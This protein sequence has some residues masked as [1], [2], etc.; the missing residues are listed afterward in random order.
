MTLAEL[1]GHTAKQ[2]QDGKLV[3]DK[4][5]NNDI[6]FKLEEA[7]HRMDKNQS[8][9]NLTDTQLERLLRNQNLITDGKCA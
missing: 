7:T 3:S 6:R 9:S 2:L 5:S 4:K 1:V 8:I